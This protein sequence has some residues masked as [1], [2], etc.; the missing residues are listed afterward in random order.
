MKKINLRVSMVVDFV[1]NDSILWMNMRSIREESIRIINQ[2][3]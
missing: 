2:S 1:E 3:Y